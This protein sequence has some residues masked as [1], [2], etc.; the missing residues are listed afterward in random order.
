MISSN[1]SDEPGMIDLA[2]RRFERPFT[3]IF[4]ATR[5]PA[6]LRVADARL[7]QEYDPARAK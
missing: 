5:V 7:H 2:V 4:T 1:D 6:L 3:P